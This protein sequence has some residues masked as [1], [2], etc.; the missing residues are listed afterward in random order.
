MSRSCLIIETSP[1]IWHYL[2][3][4]EDAPSGSWDW[5]EHSS[6]FG[7]F[8]T[9]DEAFEHRADNHSNVAGS[10]VVN[11]SPELLVPD[12]VAQRIAEA[13]SSTRSY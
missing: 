11:Y 13:A 4:D 3:E 6:A 10:E 5:R 2:V 9:R 12:V 1:D 7:P 8:D